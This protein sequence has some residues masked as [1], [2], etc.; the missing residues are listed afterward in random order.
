MTTNIFKA[1][2]AAALAVLLSV[3]PVSYLQAADDGAKAGE[4]KDGKKGK[5]KEKEPDCD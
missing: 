3:A 1:S 2:V 5:G 4:S